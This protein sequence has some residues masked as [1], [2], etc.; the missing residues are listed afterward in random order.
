MIELQIFVPL[1][2][3]AIQ[4]AG[5]VLSSVASKVKDVANKHIFDKTFVES[6]ISESN[7]QLAD[8]LKVATSDIKQ[9]IREQGVIDVIQDL[10]ADITVLGK[11][12]DLANTS[13]L[14]PAIA[15]RLIP[16]ALIPL[17]KN[18]EKARL[19]L[20]QYG[21]NDIGSYCQIVGTSTLIA[22]YAFLGQNVPTLQKELQNSIYNFQ[23]HLLD[24]IA[25]I[26]IQANK[27]I[28]W[29]KI[30]H[31]ITI[32]GVPELYSLYNSTLEFAPKNKGNKN[33][34]IPMKVPHDDKHITKE[35]FSKLTYRQK[36]ALTEYGYLLSPED[37]ETVGKM[38]GSIVRSRDI[39]PFCREHGKEILSL[40]K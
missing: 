21:S 26:T 27:E 40:E 2:V 39:L 23:K 25:L 19:R 17:Q 4:S 13:E 6:I 34:L 22:G 14:S 8:L 5:Q 1:M 9:E 3:A 33:Q 30:P 11:L 16:N 36:F 24:E 31:L 29:E 7:D 20:N 38:L 35:D 12:L 18:L 10:Q 28:P 32:D 15:E 37:A